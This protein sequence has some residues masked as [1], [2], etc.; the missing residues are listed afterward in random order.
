MMTIDPNGQDIHK[1]PLPSH[2]I[3]GPFINMMAHDDT[4]IDPSRLIILVGCNPYLSII[5]E[6]TSST[7]QL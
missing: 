3:A 2:M 5:Q 7:S 1:N 4:D 6:G